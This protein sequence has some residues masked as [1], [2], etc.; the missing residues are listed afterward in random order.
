MFSQYAALVKNLRGVVFAYFE[1]ENVEE[2]LSWLTKKF[3]YR[4]LGVP[5]TIYSKVEKYFE[6]KINGKPF[7]KLEYPVHSL[8]N[9]VKLIGENFKIEY[10]VVETVILASTYVSPIMVMGWEAFKKL[11]KICASRVDS[12]ISLND[13]GWKL[14]F[15]IVDYTVLD[16]YGW[17]VNHSKQLWSQKLNLKKFLEERKNKIE[18]DKKRY[19]RL[20]KGEEKPFPLILYV[21]LAQLIAQKLEN[22]NFKKKFLGLPVEEVSAGLA[23]EATIFLVR[24]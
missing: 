1:K 5:P 11:E 13:F 7:V 23:I 12:T 6:G 20:Q 4:N 16:F 21:D 22:K 17:S 10:E 2:T 15:R 14:H 9:L 24:S 3:K 18:K 8:K 19:W